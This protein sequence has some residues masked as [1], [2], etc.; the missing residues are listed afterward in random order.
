MI[1]RISHR[2]V[3]RYS[4][5][6]KSA[7]QILRLTPR[8]HEGQFVKDW[9]ITVDQDCKLTEIVDALGN[10]THTF[11]IDGPLEELTVHVE[12][13]VLTHDTGGLVAGT[14]ERFMPEMF[15]RTTPLSE[16]N[17]ALAA[18]AEK[19]VVKAGANVLEQCHALN[20]AIHA[21]MKFNTDPTDPGTTAAE[22]FATRHGV[23]QDFTHVFVSAARLRGI[24]ARYVGGYLLRYD[25]DEE[26]EA[27]HAWAEAYV[28]DLGWVAF[29]PT[30]G[31]CATE[32]YVRIAVG[33][34]Y[35][36]ASPV[37][38]ARYGGADETMA[39]HVAVAE[40]GQ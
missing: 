26:Q 32:H 29:D 7:I 10:I 16:P 30:H 3:Y 27:G 22:A 4:Q 40:A 39:V 12:G 14:M 8:D 33:F 23:C 5:P 35:L 1:I 17:R 19:A 21:R 13:E 9:R 20:R 36:G 34:D 37:R 25:G 38:G 11:T 2:T 31:I 15:L 28:P 24:P 18:F 6:V